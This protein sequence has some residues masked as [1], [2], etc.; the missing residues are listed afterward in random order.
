MTWNK[1]K[2]ADNNIKKKNYVKDVVKD[3]KVKIYKKIKV[4]LLYQV[5]KDK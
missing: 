1:Y 2:N 5:N 4:I 3:K